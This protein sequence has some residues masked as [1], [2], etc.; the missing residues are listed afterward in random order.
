MQIPGSVLALIPAR[1][2]SK[3]LPGKNIIEFHGRPLIHWSI[4]AALESGCCNTVLV[5]TD[6]REIADIAIAGGAIAPWL[7]PQ[8]LADDKASTMAAVVHA[9][10]QSPADIV[11]VLQPTS[12]LRTAGDVAACVS[13]YRETGK[14]VVSVCPAK[15]WLFRKTNSGALTPAIEF[16]T[17]RQEVEYFSPNGAVYVFSAE[18]LRSGDAWWSVGAL[19]YLMPPE[20]SVDIDTPYDLTVAKAVYSTHAGGEQNS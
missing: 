10:D 5:S 6:S 19:P 15:P 18:F 4:S 11:V 2:G 9:L 13:L 3:G 14:P 17:Q 8:H 1:S 20:R 12:P 16:A 7:R